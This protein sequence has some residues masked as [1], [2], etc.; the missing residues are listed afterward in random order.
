VII[1]FQ[2][3]FEKQDSH[4]KKILWGRETFDYA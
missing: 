4:S 2:L 3:F 1:L